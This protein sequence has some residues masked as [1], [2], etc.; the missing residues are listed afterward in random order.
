METKRIAITDIAGKKL[1]IEDVCVET[2]NGY[3]TI[4]DY[5]K[6]NYY[7]MENF[8]VCEVNDC[9]YIGASD[10]DPYDLDTILDGIDEE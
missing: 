2:L 8:V 3:E 6:G 10:P 5:V 7:P 4:E 1:F 9:Q